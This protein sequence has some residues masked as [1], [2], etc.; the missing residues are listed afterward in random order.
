LPQNYEYLL[1]F[2]KTFYLTRGGQGGM[3][4]PS[5][6][7]RRTSSQ[8]P[9]DPFNLEDELRDAQ[10]RLEEAKGALDRETQRIFSLHNQKTA[11]EQRFGEL[12]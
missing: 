12:A 9:L 1:F 7:A 11:L 3:A 4:E 5:L 2:I 8:G 10:R 6:N